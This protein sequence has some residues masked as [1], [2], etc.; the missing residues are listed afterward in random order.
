MCERARSTRHI[1]TIRGPVF[2]L[3]SAIL[4]RPTMWCFGTDA[5]FVRIV[6]FQILAVIQQAES[7]PHLHFNAGAADLYPSG[8]VDLIKTPTD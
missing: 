7:D 6:A 3:F 1:G 5:S 2:G 4:C 8:N